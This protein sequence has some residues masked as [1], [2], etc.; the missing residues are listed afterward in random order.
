MS[1]ETGRLAPATV[2]RATT[3][4]VGALGALVALVAAL[5]LWA[6]AGGSLPESLAWVGAFPGGQDVLAPLL[7]FGGA[8]VGVALARRGWLAVVAPPLVAG[9]TAAVVRFGVRIA[10]G[11][12]FSLDVLARGF[13]QTFALG[14]A[15]GSVAAL[16]LTY[17]GVRR[18]AVAVVLA[19]AGVV[20]ATFAFS[21]PDVVDYA[22]RFGYAVVAALALGLLAAG[23]AYATRA[24]EPHD[25]EEGADAIGWSSADEPAVEDESGGS[26]WAESDPSD[27][28][29]DEE[30][31]DEGARG[32]AAVDDDTAAS[33][34]GADAG[35]ATTDVGETGDVGTDTDAVADTGADVG[36]TSDAGETG[37]A[38]SESPEETVS[39]GTDDVE[40]SAEEAVPD[41]DDTATGDAATDAEGTATD[42]ETETSDADGDA[43][44]DE[45]RD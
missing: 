12:A 37:D 36:E 3:A 33:A 18:S 20:G 30:W 5:R 19:V 44:G 9:V 40:T 39:S 1:G 4:A 41:A 6:G 38:G 21:T 8:L 26:T 22:V 17:P 15:V 14:V 7:A 32:D 16:G 2:H 25:D 11:S 27:W 28:D 34:T 31:N 45:T 29:A 35:E 10:A 13:G 43:P 23:L 24:V 42:D